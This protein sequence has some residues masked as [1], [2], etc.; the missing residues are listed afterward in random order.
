MSHKLIIRICAVIMAASGV[1]ILFSTLFPIISYEWES[2]RRYPILISPLVD[3]ETASFKFSK[4]DYTKASS[5]F[6]GKKGEE[7]TPQEVKYFTISVPKLNIENAT[8]AI[9]GE[10][11][12]KSLIQ[13]AGTALPGKVGNSVIFGHSI[14]PIFYDPKNYLAIFSTLN[15][16]KK[17]DKAFVDY[18]GISYEYVVEDMFEVRP[19]DTQIL[20]QNSSESFLTLVTCTP[21]GDPRKPKRLI[22]RA[23]LIPPDQ[24]NAYLRN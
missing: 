3:K 20:E 19:S 6:E 18:D 16:L 7:S 4:K 24:K 15:K 2:A 11:L 21:P 22:V 12:S 23:R 9:G 10:D 1:V 14:L 17:G 5:W 8:V 13:F